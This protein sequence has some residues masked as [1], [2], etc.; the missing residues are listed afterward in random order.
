LPG[1]E[2]TRK[3]W[4]RP[5]NIRSRDPHRKSVEK[6][7]YPRGRSNSLGRRTTRKKTLFLVGRK[8]K[9]QKGGGGR[10]PGKKSGRPKK[11]ARKKRSLANPRWE[12]KT[13]GGREK[14]TFR[15]VGELLL[16]S[17]G[18]GK[19]I[20][21]YQLL[22]PTVTHVKKKGNEKGFLRLGGPGGGWAKRRKSFDR[23]GGWYQWGGKK[24][25]GWGAHR[26]EGKKETRPV[27]NQTP[28]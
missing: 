26:W 8:S 1:A 11:R 17:F 4:S 25:N 28:A 2:R 5:T 10:Q 22:E 6:T 13:P 24:R 21:T 23:G 14:K 19:K 3:N 27:W 15:P 16:I 7:Y 18:K 20:T 9:R 12:T